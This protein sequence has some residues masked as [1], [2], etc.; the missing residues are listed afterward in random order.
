[1]TFAQTVFRVRGRRGGV[2]VLLY[3]FAAFPPLILALGAAFALAASGRGG[4]GTLAFGCALGLWV[5]GAMLWAGVALGV[6]RLHDMDM[7]GAHL[8][9]VWGVP[10]AA[11][12]LADTAGVD[13]LGDVVTYGVMIWLCCM[14]GT[15]GPNRFGGRAS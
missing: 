13:L 6:K 15:S 11:N 7:S 14:P 12:I 2:D 8:V 1:M 4:T 3:S 5:L 10:L 9:W